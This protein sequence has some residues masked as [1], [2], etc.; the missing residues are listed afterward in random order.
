MKKADKEKINVWSLKKEKSCGFD[1]NLLE[2][3]EKGIDL[4]PAIMCVIL[5]GFEFLWILSRVVLFEF[6]YM[7]KFIRKSSPA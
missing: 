2:F 3:E 5:L 4:W 7:Q 1:I 6:Q